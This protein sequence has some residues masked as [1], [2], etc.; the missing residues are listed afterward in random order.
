MAEWRIESTMVGMHDGSTAWWLWVGGQLVRG[1]TVAMGGK[2]EDAGGLELESERH[3]HE[4]KRSDKLLGL[5]LCVY[6]YK[7]VF[8]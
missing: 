5:F 7:R 1:T 6:M 8:E 4:G 3:S 2:E